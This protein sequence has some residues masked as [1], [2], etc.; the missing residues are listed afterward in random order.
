MQAQI[1]PQVPNEEVSMNVLAA[2]VAGVAGTAVFSAIAAAAPS[3]GMAR[4]AIWEILGS[5]FNK[6]GNKALG[7]V[8]HFMMGAIFAIVY[9]A[10]W[11]AGLGSASLGSG[12]LFGALH[13]LAA[14]LAMGMVPMLHAGVRAGTVQAPGAYMLGSGGALAFMGGLVGHVAYGIIVGVVYGGLAG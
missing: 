10:L 2:I 5:M 6:E 9:A 7:W 12:A 13:W 3:M 8:A 1:R 4:M 11:S 14:G